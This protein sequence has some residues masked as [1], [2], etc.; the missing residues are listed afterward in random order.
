MQ[1]LQLYIE[2]QRL[3]LFDDETVSLTQSIQNVRDIAKIFTDFSK[4]FTLPASKN[5]NKIFK[6]Y[7]NYDIDN[8]FDARTKKDA[9]IE[10]NNLPFT[11]GKIKL[12]GVGLKNNNPNTYRITF[13]GSTVTLKDLLGDDKLQSLDLTSYNKEYSITGIINALSFNPETVDVI[14]PL[15]T[16]SRRLFYDSTS[17]HAHDDLLSGNLF[18]ESGLAHT[19]GVQWDDLKYAIRLHKIVEAIETKYNITFSDDFLVDTNS[20]YYNLFMWL[21]RKKGDVENF[22]DVNQS[23]VSGWSVTSLGDTLTQMFSN[24]IMRV[25]GEPFRYLDYSLTF[26]TATAFNY[27][28]SLLKDGVEVYNTG[29]VPG[30]NV[31]INQIDFDIEQGDYTAYVQSDDNISFSSVEWDISY[32]AGSFGGI[33][34]DVYT[35]TSYNHNNAFNFDIS[36]QIP[37]MKIIDLL[38]GIFRMFNLTAYVEND[39]IVVKTLDAYYDSGSSYDISKYID[40]ASSEVNLALPYREI[41][42]EHEDT[43]TFLATKHTQLFGKVWGKESFVGGERLDGDIYNIK[44][45]FSQ[46]KYERLVNLN[47]NLNT[48]IQYGYFVDDNQDSYFGK[49][50]LFYPILITGGTPISFVTNE[51]SHQSKNSYIIPSNS[52]A[53]SSAT[54]KENMNFYAETNE[55][56]GNNDFTDT[57]FKKYYE[58][59]ITSVFNLQNR[60]T[61]VT[62]YLPLRILLKYT[63]ADRFVIN[64]RSFKINSINTNLNTGKSVIELLNDL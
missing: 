20:H 6:H 47:D 26:T 28:V 23:I 58:K 34:E 64:N 41:N 36:Q 53:L 31:T 5:N 4:T 7:Y 63:L 35:V 14:V 27:K 60:L 30:G 40:I 46:L 59:Y 61:K 18:Y 11:N 50:L 51:T 48:T 37:E 55:Y 21:H 24:S 10:L 15:I 57:L 22:S 9:I 17:G 8:G 52:V 2:G 19:H 16:H 44:T 38:T 45:P 29:N 3:D 54:S 12:E 56:T 62:A 13:F 1:K 25:T 33:V 32:N 39:I 49:A 43:N 42:F